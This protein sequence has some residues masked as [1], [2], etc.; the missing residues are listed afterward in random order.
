MAMSTFLF[1][2]WLDRR[3][4][5]FV[6]RSFY[7]NAL[8]TMKERVG[9]S[10]GCADND[11]LTS[12][13]LLQMYEVCI[14]R[15][16]IKKTVG[17][18]E[19]RRKRLLG[20]VNQS[21]PG[22]AHLEGALALIKHRGAENFRDE[23]GQGLLFAVR[24]QLVGTCLFIRHSLADVIR[25]TSPSPQVSLWLKSCRPG[26]PILMRMPSH[27]ASRST[28]S[29]STSPISQQPPANILRF[30]PIS[31]RI[32]YHT[33]LKFSKRHR[34]SNA[35]SKNGQLNYHPHGYQSPFR[36]PPY[37]TVFGVRAYIK[38]TV[39]Y[40]PLSPSPQPGTKTASP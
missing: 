38:T 21:Q 30:L 19:L 28:P 9:R 25:S 29:M 14:S 8:S 15:F 16:P 13:L 37:Q 3:P 22:R 1:V 5:T 2:A 6:S 24:Q 35:D 17:S 18:D 26:H 33:P 4:D 40:T 27:Q 23:V 34:P 7:L 36:K 39:T 10:E 20:Y 11:V 31:D 12:V 32:C